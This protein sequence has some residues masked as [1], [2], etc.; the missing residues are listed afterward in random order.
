MSTFLQNDTLRVVATGLIEATLMVDTME[1]PVK[2][3]VVNK[4]PSRPIKYSNALRTALQGRIAQNYP[5]LASTTALI[6][7]KIQ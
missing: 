1:H 4:E 3:L 2:A 6:P 5:F 7:V